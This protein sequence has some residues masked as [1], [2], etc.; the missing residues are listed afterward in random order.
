MEE[1]LNKKYRDRLRILLIIYFFS[2]PFQDNDKPKV[3]ARLKSEV[4]VQKLDF[5]IRYP[6]YLCY[7]LMLKMNED[8]SIDRSEIKKLVGE[9]ID[10]HEPEIRTI[11]MRKFL[12]GAW[13]NLD[14]TINFLKSHGLIDFESKIDSS[15]KQYN[16]EY[17]LTSFGKQKVENGLNTI[18][19]L[20]WYSDRCAIIKKYF[21]DLKGSEL[22][23]LQYGHTQYKDAMIN[24]YIHDIAEE[25]KNM[26][27]KEFNEAL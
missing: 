26:F 13:E 6:S 11:D 25:A 17:F 22:K 24:Q 1:N 2:E 15:L 19:G 14:K 3:I 16:K 27:N 23:A 10:S 18:S 8:S 5:L 7:E 20:K 4:K 21:G 12:Y 9:I